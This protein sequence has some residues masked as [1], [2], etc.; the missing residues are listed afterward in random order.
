MDPRWQKIVSFKGIVPG[1]LLRVNV[2]IVRS[3]NAMLTW[4]PPEQENENMMKIIMLLSVSVCTSKRH[5]RTTQVTARGKFQR[6]VSY[7]ELGDTR[8]TVSSATILVH[9]LVQGGV[10]KLA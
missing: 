8:F 6:E 9:E 5:A 10:Y 2:E 3:M 1:A 7:I 4:V